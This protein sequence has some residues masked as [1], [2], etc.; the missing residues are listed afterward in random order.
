[1]GWGLGLYGASGCVS[2]PLGKA[3]YP[4]SYF[5]KALWATASTPSWGEKPKLE[6]HIKLSKMYFIYKPMIKH[7]E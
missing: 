2:V 5:L 6:N 4:H 7:T 1:M 3:S